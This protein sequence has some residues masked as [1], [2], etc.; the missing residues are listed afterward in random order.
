MVKLITLNCEGDNHLDTV[1][2]FIAK[3]KPD[4][5]CLQEV[6][7]KDLPSIKG[8][9]RGEVI[10][11]CVIGEDK[12]YEGQGTGEYGTVI[13]TRLKGSSRGEFY[14]GKG[15][16]PVFTVANSDGCLLVSGTYEK[17]GKRYTIATT[18]FWWTPKGRPDKEQ[19]EA[20]NSLLKHLDRFDDL[21]LCGDFNAPRGGP[22]FTQLAKR[23]RDNLPASVTSTLDP[24]KHEAG[25][26]QFVVDT[27]FTTPHYK[28]S[29]IRVVEGVSDHK[30][31]VAIIERVD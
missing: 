2:P 6:F 8:D 11:T 17:D 3:E 21:V 10:P 16:V 7:V 23:F 30:A 31:V 15:D 12:M 29:E 24:V 28:V 22:I 9:L 5:A 19:W 25:H 18:K 14:A 4:I 1:V 20:L 27:I 13:L 26:R